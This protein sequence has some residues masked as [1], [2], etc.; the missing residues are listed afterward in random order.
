ML[1]GT[2]PMTPVIDLARIPAHSDTEEDPREAE[3]PRKSP[4]LLLANLWW[5]VRAAAPR[6]IF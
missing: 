2:S 6:V 5:R 4:P 1:I 3:N